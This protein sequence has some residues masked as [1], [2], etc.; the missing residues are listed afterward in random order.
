MNLKSWI[1]RVLVSW[2][3]LDTKKRLRRIFKTSKKEGPNFFITWISEI[4]LFFVSRVT[5]RF[6]V[7]FSA[8]L[9][10]LRPGQSKYPIWDSVSDVTQRIYV[11][12][13][14]EKCWDLRVVFNFFVLI[15]TEFFAISGNE[16][17]VKWASK[18][19]ISV[20]TRLLDSIKNNLA[21]HATNLSQL[22]HTFSR[23]TKVFSKICQ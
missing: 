13:S 15:T 1:Y 21:L 16:L 3:C 22:L 10:L 12:S 19:N 6:S 5:T 18:P 2:R 11:V 4:K 14:I 9:E 20:K 23:L 8:F 17:L 7:Y